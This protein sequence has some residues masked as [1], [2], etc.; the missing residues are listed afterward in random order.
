MRTQV[1]EMT[2][3]RACR[4]II[5]FARRVGL[6]PSPLRRSVDRVESLLVMGAILLAVAALPVAV[7]TGRA[8]YDGALRTA[9]TQAAASSQVGATLVQD[10]P[11]V[12]DSSGAVATSPAL[13]VWTTADGSV[14][15]GQVNAPAGSPAWAT[16]SIW[17]D[18]QGQPVSPPLTTEQAAGRGLVT[19]VL[20]ELAVI[21][22]LAGVVTLLRWP[23]NRRRDADWENEWRTVGPRWTKYRI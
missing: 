5:W 14:R 7:A 10:A 20:A 4:P 22:A 11:D 9:A 3:V 16:V 1:I 18:P 6:A 21:L 15:S 19:G 23:L 13:A 12:T 2:I 17:I 8:T